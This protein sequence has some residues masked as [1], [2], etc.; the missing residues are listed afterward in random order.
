MPVHD[1]SQVEAGIY[2]DFH[3]SWIPEIRKAL[4][5]GLLPEG[6]YVMAEQHAGHAIADVLTLQRHITVPE[7]TSH[8]DVPGTGGTALAE[9]PPRVRK[10]KIIRPEY[11]SLRRSL[12]LRH[13]SGHRLVALIE[14]L[15]PGN[16][17]RK[18]AVE[19]FVTKAWSA[20]RAGI[21]MLIIDLFPPGRHD[22]DGINGVIAREL[23]R[24]DE[25]ECP[26]AEEPFTLASY[27]A[28]P[29]VEVFTEHIATGGLL[30]EMPLF[31]SPDR[32]VNVPLEATYQRAFD[33]FP[34][35]LREV[36]EGKRSTP[37]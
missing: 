22:P 30:P 15:S 11:V 24:S 28:G 18:Q 1:W 23:E 31:I 32:Y 10:R 37:P 9:A 21:H 14:I 33:G 2:H 4:N 7:T 26:P 8:Q 12:A 27:L 13:V 17:D 34:D 6:F 5:N 16:K 25:L 20:L 19:E 35:F 36:L 3:V 29:P